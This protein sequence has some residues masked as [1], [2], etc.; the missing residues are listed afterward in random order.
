MRTRTLET[1]QRIARLGSFSQAAEE[2]NMT[3]SSVSMQ[4]KALEEELDAELFD[5]SNRPPTLTPLGRRIAEQAASVLRE[6]QML[7]ELCSP[8]PGLVGTFRLGVI[9]SMATRVIPKF[10]QLAP[11]Q[12]PHAEF[13]VSTGLSADLSLA[14]LSGHLDAAIVT[15]A[16]RVDPG[17][18]VDTLGRD[19]MVFAVPKSARGR[20]V[21]QLAQELRFLHFKPQSGI[22]RVIAATLADQKIDVRGARIFDSIETTMECVNIGIGFTLLPKPDVQRYAAAG[23]RLVNV[24]RG[25]V[26]RE[27][28]LVTRKEPSAERWRA[29]LLHLLT[30]AQD[31]TLKRRSSKPVV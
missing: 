7:R 5:R 28:A 17:L 9:S 25:T 27:V 16:G 31:E 21:K 12:A 26:E 6:D 4:M 20:T 30:L 13:D 8:G 1:L 29:A 23:V 2:A 11:A 3:V 18:N 24:G 22:G 19:P 10:L 14:V 15:Q